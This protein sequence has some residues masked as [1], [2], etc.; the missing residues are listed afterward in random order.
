MI[1]LVVSVCAITFI[2]INVNR[3]SKK[4]KKLQE[5]VFR[6]NKENKEIPDEA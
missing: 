2:A 1:Y 4:I 6:A 3:N 5:K